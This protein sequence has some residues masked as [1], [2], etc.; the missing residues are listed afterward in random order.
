M[1]ARR[2]EA[3]IFVEAQA[4]RADAARRSRPVVAV[5]TDALQIATNVAAITRSRIP[6]EG[7]TAELVGEVHAFIETVVCVPR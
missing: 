3:A 7:S 5:H 1:A 4:V 6:D 2:I